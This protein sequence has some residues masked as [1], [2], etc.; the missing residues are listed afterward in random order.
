M[1]P[2]LARFAARIDAE[3]AHLA[4]RRTQFLQ[5]VLHARIVGMALDV[6]VEQRRGEGAELVAL[7]L[8]HVDAVGGE[9][10]HR[11]VERGRHVA[12]AEDEG[13]HHP[14]SGGGRL[15][16]GFLVS[17][18]KRVTLV[19]VSSTFSSRMSRP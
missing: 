3:N 6:G 5:R 17:T 11:L 14:A 8:G 19:S 4:S 7:Q 18:T 10:A 13:G 1:I 9:A 12:H 2:F 15:D 16:P